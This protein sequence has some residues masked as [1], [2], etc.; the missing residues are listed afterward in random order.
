MAQ[1]LGSSAVQ[2]AADIRDLSQSFK[3][4]LRTLNRSEET[5]RS[6]I[7]TVGPLADFLQNHGLSTS[8]CDIEREN[9][10][11]F[12]ADQLARWTYGIIDKPDWQMHASYQERVRDVGVVP[13]LITP[14]HRGLTERQQRH[15]RWPWV[16]FSVGKSVP[17]AIASHPEST[18]G[19][20]VA[21]RMGLGW[22]CFLVASDAPDAPV[23]ALLTKS[24][25]H[26]WRDQPTIVTVHGD[27]RPGGMFAVEFPDGT[28]R[29]SRSRARLVTWPPKPPHNFLGVI[30]G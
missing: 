20:G 9:V 23:G 22:V 21:M 4:S 27:P 18:S 1:A 8:I 24:P 13:P 19:V 25:P 29:L 15:L 12:I 2:D 11:S 17:N 26:R 30:V 14:P 6:Y 28:V 16:P 10:E 3:R 7:F 5:I